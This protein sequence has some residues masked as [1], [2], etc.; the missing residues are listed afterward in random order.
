MLAS[1][2]GHGTCRLYGCRV[3]P[4]S[5][6]ASPDCGLCC[7]K[8]CRDQVKV[9]CKKKLGARG[10]VGPAGAPTPPATTPHASC[11]KARMG[12]GWWVGS[13]CQGHETLPI[14]TIPLL[15]P[16]TSQNRFRGQS[17]RGTR[18]WLPPAPCLDPDRLL[19]PLLGPGNGEE[20]VPPVPSWMCKGQIIGLGKNRSI[21]EECMRK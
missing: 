15:L 20:E 9:E 14:T 5:L 16:Y 19:T 17:P 6:L 18:D 2:R 21:L 7:H 1:G 4:R 10:D 12:E 8:H 11:G 3:L 13:Q